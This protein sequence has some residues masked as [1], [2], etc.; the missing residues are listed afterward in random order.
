V[1]L[2]KPRLEP[3]DASAFDDEVREILGG[4]GGLG[5]GRPLNIFT[6]LAHHPKLLKRWLVF[7]NHV[8]AKSTLS[9]RHR[10]L[11]ILRVGWL[12]RAEYEWGQHVAIA[13]AAGVSD[14]EIERVTAGP[15]APGWSEAESAL[16]RAVDELRADAFVR[17][18]TWAVLTRH[19]DV[20]QLLD[21]IFTV[22]Q[23]QL[24]SMALNTLGVQRDPGVAGFPAG[25]GGG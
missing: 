4:L 23:Y 24:V 13:R 5:G 3:L 15:D 22:G 9:P 7:G 14:A 20:R 8:L 2:T 21:L 19:Y 17:D 11:A 25:R 1:R 10:E 16:L 18:A 6:T 12:C